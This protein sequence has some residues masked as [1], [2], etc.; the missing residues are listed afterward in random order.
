MWHAQGGIGCCGML[1]QSIRR[2]HFRKPVRFTYNGAPPRGRAV[3]G[4]APRWCEG[5]VSGEKG[6]SRGVGQAERSGRAH[7]WG[8]FACKSNLCN[9]AA[10]AGPSTNSLDATALPTRA[11]RRG[12]HGRGVVGME[13]G[14]L[15]ASAA[16]RVGQQATPESSRVNGALVAALGFRRR[17]GGRH[18]LSIAKSCLASRALSD[19]PA[20]ATADRLA[21]LGPE[22]AD[23]AEEGR[24]KR[25]QARCSPSPSNATELA[26]GDVREARGMAHNRRREP[27]GPE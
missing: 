8:R 21:D 16:F 6:S 24:R 18:M 19:V 10:C 26:R 25:V 7:S 22:H 11:R 23:A 12:R 14:K 5:G 4:A 2:L 13:R 20:V 15:E 3:A 1:I 27:S 9:E 17:G